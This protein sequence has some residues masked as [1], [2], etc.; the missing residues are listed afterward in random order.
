MKKLLVPIA[1]CALFAACGGVG[2]RTPEMILEEQL[3]AFHGHMLWGRYDDAATFVAAEE[4]ERFLG[5]YDELGEDYDVTEFDLTKV[6]VDPGGEVATVEVWV[7]AFRLP[8]TRVDERT[9]SERW[10]YDRELRAWKMVERVE[11]DD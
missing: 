5:M 3:Q 4:R 10:E 7:Q 6:E 2:M 1:T 9:Y 11:L 8:S